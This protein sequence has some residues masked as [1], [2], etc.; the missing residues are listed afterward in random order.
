MSSGL[1]TNLS[2]FP[3]GTKAFFFL[4]E[5]PA[6]GSSSG[7]V[8]SPASLAAPS[9]SSS[10]SS[11]T[12]AGDGFFFSRFAGAAAF[13]F[14]FTIFGGLPTFLGIAIFL[15]ATSSFL[16]LP[17]FMGGL[18]VFMGGLE[19]FMGDLVDVSVAGEDG[20][21]FIA[22]SRLLSPAFFIVGGG[23]FLTAREGDGS[24]LIGREGDGC[25]LFTDREGD[26]SFFI[27]RPGFFFS[28]GR[29]G[30][31]SFLIGREGDGS[32]LMNGREGDTFSFF[33]T[34]AGLADD[35]SLET[36]AVVPSALQKCPDLFLGLT[37]ARD[38]AFFLA[39]SAASASSNFVTFILGG[40]DSRL[41]GTDI[42]VL[43][44]GLSMDGTEAVD[45]DADAGSSHDDAGDIERRDIRGEADDGS[46][47]PSSFFARKGAR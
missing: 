2:P 42:V 46:F 14:F 36:A 45:A 35:G 13:S 11:F 34:D 40:A 47:G 15:G 20:A 24:F 9:T 19:V 31:G 17:T 41:R 25:F 6:A 30:D 8:S 28:T 29:E 18:D 38:K 1:Y 39:N 4:C 3:V 12:I 33:L 10:A 7:S 16:G 22:M 44:L 26:G 43:V 32:F 37:F 21:F 5:L 23:F 27:G